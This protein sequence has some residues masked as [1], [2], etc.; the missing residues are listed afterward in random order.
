M[1]DKRQIRFESQPRLPIG[2]NPSL[3]RSSL[4]PQQQQRLSIVPQN[5][6]SRNFGRDNTILT[7]NVKVGDITAQQRSENTK[8]YISQIQ[9]LKR[10]SQ[11]TQMI[12]IL[13][14]IVATLCLLFISFSLQALSIS[15]LFIG[16][17][18][19]LCV[20]ETINSGLISVQILILIC[21][22]YSWIL[23]SYLI[24]S[25]Q[26][27]TLPIQSIWIHLVVTAVCMLFPVYLF[28]RNRAD[29]FNTT[30]LYL[31]A[32]LITFVTII[33]FEDFV[34]FNNIGYAITR[35]ILSIVLTLVIFYY[36]VITS[37][38]T[39]EHKFRLYI[40]I[41]YVFFGEPF[42]SVAFFVIHLAVYIFLLANKLQ[43]IELS[44][45]SRDGVSQIKE[46]Q[47]MTSH[48]RSA[49]PN[50]N[51]GYDMQFNQ[52]AADVQLSTTKQ[53]KRQSL[54]PQ[55]QIQQRQQQQIQG[56]SEEE[57]DDQ[58][59]FEHVQIQKNHVIDMNLITKTQ[60]G[61]MLNKNN[62][63]Q[64]TQQEEFHQ[65]L[66]TIPRKK[67]KKEKKEKRSD[68]DILS[69]FQ[70]LQPTSSHQT[71]DSF[72]QTNHSTENNSKNDHQQPTPYNI[73]SATINTA[74]SFD[75]QELHMS[76]DFV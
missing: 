11:Q 13:S 9:S 54:L 15:I 30:T 44:K 23:H 19:G 50:G 76:K 8:T 24:Y 75:E 36:D 66:A 21:T 35:V 69:Q 22:W 57:N 10:S 25:I 17:L 52:T 7:D 14:M 42:I 18:V 47:Q 60:N 34:M 70:Q 67:E 71:H 4:S 28:A 51:S 64:Q 20:Y 65:S 46:Q 73:P 48:L 37:Q 58:D 62:Q 72:E 5:E 40:Q 33:P 43:Q 31:M 1:T 45:S 29:P 41:V 12:L 61:R 74:G 53:K 55:L 49:P 38:L 6:N 27:H 63:F 39:T 3:T 16:V 2:M 59:G 56:D 26:D 68:N 32:A